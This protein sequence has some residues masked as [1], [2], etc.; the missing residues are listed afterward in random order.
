MP[1]T[2]SFLLFLFF[3]ISFFALFDVLTLEAVKREV[4]QNPKSEKGVDLRRTFEQLVLE[5]IAHVLK[6]VDSGVLSMPLFL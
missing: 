1:Y 4:I 2:L 5:P 6:V 3:A